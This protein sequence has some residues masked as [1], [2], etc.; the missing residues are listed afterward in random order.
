[1]NVVTIYKHTTHTSRGF[2]LI[3]LLI[4]IAIIGILSSVVLASLNTARE[5]ARDAKRL[6]DTRNVV[7]A[8]ELYYYDN[9]GYPPHGGSQYDCNSS[10]CLAV[11]TDELVTGGYLPSIPLDPTYGNTSSGYR[12]CRVSNTREYA[13]LTRMES[14]DNSWCSVDTPAIPS[15]SSCWFTG[16]EPNYGWCRDE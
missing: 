11:L 7:A 9:D 12:Y 8:L 5:K 15:G 16:G 14:G 13:I 1:M 4:V 3:E 10:T 2:T 6:S